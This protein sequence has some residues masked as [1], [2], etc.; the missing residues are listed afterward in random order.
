[1]ILYFFTADEHYFHKNILLYAKRP[2]SSIKE[3]NEILILNHNS[4]VSPSDTVVHVGDFT[5]KKKEHAHRILSKLN[6][7][8]IFIMGSHDRWLS[9]STNY[10]KQFKVKGRHIIA[11]HYAM[12]V[13]PRSHYNSWL[14]Y[15]HSHGNLPPQGKSWD[16]GVDNNNYFP[17]SF[18]ELVNIMNDRE[19][20]FNLVR[21]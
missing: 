19:D 17:V 7:N 8:H 3:M 18:D 4:V 12:R 6:G 9:K 13:W 20:N 1:M 11:C 5:L 21:R 14:V 2:F 10:L 15:G 16:V